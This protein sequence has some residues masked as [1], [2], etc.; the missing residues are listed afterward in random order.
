MKWN[1]SYAIR[2]DERSALVGQIDDEMISL[3]YRCAGMIEMHINRSA[4]ER[5]TGQWSP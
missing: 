1:G 4:T 2:T 5:V 3:P